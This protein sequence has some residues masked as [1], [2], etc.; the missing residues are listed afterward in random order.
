MEI[1]V[2]Y[3]SKLR[4]AALAVSRKMASVLDVMFPTAQCRTMRPKTKPAAATANTSESVSLCV[5]HAVHG[6]QED[7]G[8]ENPL[9]QAAHTL[10][11]NPIG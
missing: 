9:A 6:E 4:A 11:V 2:K 1:D 8:L 7:A 10:S 5:V 3:K